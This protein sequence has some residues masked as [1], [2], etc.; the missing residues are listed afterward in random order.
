MRESPLCPLCDYPVPGRSPGRCP[1]CG[2]IDETPHDL[3][4]ASPRSCTVPDEI[5]ELVLAIVLVGHALVTSALAF[6]I[7]WT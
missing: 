5:P 4:G 1:E 6:G 7:V 2:A 3:D